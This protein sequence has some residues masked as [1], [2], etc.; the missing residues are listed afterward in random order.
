MDSIEQVKA[1]IVE[2]RKKGLSPV[3]VNTYVR[4]VKAFYL[5][6]GREFKLKPLLEEQKILPTLSPEQLAG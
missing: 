1:R 2:L 3:T 4:H 5:W 6:Q